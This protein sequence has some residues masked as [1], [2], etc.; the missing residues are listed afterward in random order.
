MAQQFPD[1]HTTSVS[2][3]TQETVVQTDVRFDSTYLRTRDGILKISQLVSDQ[4][5]FIS[6]LNPAIV[7]RS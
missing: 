2:V 7:C 3:K 6:A 1:H 4:L 5:A